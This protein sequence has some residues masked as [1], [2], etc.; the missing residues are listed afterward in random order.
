MKKHLFLKSLLIAIGLLVTSLTTQV[1]AGD[2][3]IDGFGLQFYED[4]SNPYYK[5]NGDIDDNTKMSFGNKTC[6]WTIAHVYANIKKNGENVCGDAWFGWQINGPTSTSWASPAKTSDSWGGDYHYT[7]WG[8]ENSSASRYIELVKNRKPG[9]Y[10]L[11]FIFSWKCD[12]SC[13]TTRYCKYSDHNWK[14]SW[15]IPEPTITITG[16]SSL[17]AGTSTNISASISNYPVG[18]TLTRVDVTGNLASPKYS[19]GTETS[20][21]V[22]SVTPN[23]SGANGIKVTVTVTYGTAGSKTYDYYYNVTPPATSD[24]TITPGGTGYLSSGSGTSGSPYLVT[25]NGT[26]TLGL[27]GATKAYDDGNSAAEYS[28][29]EGSSYGTTSSYTSKTISTITATSNADWTFKA[30]L[31][32]T[33]TSSLVGSVKEKTVYWKVPTYSVT[34][35][36]NG[37]STDGSATATHGKNTLSIGT[38]PTKTGYDVSGY[39][40]SDATPVLIATANGTLQTSTA[41]TDGSNKWNVLSGATL[42]AHWTAHTYTVTL[43]PGTGGSG[44][45]T[46]T[47]D[48]DA[49]AKKTWSHNITQTGYHITGWYNQTAAAGSVKV[50]N[51]DGSFAGSNV[52]GYITS[53]K[54][55]KASNCTLYAWWGGNTFTVSYD[56]NG[57]T[58][59]MSD[60]DFTYGTAQNLRT[61]TFYKDGYQFDGWATS[62]S[63]AKVYNDGVDGCRVST[64]ANITLYAHWTKVT[65]TDLTFTPATSAG[66]TSVTVTPVLSGTPTGTTSVCWGLYYDSECTRAVP[67]VTFGTNP[68]S[69][70]SSTTFTTPAASGS[71]Y[72]QATYRVGSNCSGTVLNTFVKQYVVA[73]EH[74]VIIKYKQGSTEIASRGNVVVPAAS[75]AGVKAPEIFGYTFSSWS[76]SE[77]LSNTCA[78]GASC[79]VAKDSIN[80]SATIDATLT[81]NYTRDNIIYLKNT[82]NWDTAYVNL[83]PNAWWGSDANGSGAGN[84]DLDAA[85]RNKGMKRVPGH[86]DIW[87]YNYGNTAT[88]AYV[89]FTNDSQ[90]NYYHF[91]G[92]DKNHRVSAIYPTRPNAASSENT[93]YGFNSG[94][95]M[96]VPISQTGQKWNG[97]TGNELAEYFNK[98]YWR[99]FEPATGE[100][101]YTLKIYNHKNNDGSRSLLYSV[102][103][104]DATSGSD[105]F[106][107]TIDLEAGQTYG[108]KIERDN[109]IVYTNTSSDISKN[110]NTYITLTKEANTNYAATGLATTVAGE[111]TIKLTCQNTGSLAIAAKYPAASNDYRLVYTDLVHTKKHPSDIVRRVNNGTDIVSFFVRNAKTPTVQIQSCTVNAGTG[112]VSW[113]NYG[114][115]I[116]LKTTFA[117][118]V[119]KDGVYNLYLSMNGSG[120][121]TI[122]SVKP[123][124]GDF[125]IRTDAVGGTKW[126]DYRN[127]AHKMTYS[128]YSAAN[129]GFTHYFVNWVA[130]NSNVKFTVANDYSPCISDTL[131]EDVGTVVATIIAE[132]N[133][134]AG[135][136]TSANANIRFMYNANDNSIKRAYLA[137]GQDW[138]SHFLVLQGEASKLLAPNGNALVSGNN[139]GVENNAIQLTDKQE[140]LYKTSV[141]AVPGGKVKLYARYNSVDQYFIG[142]SPIGDWTTAKAYEVLLSGDGG[143]QNISV[144][145]NFKTDRMIA[146]WEPANEINTELTLNADVMIVR[147]HQESAANITFSASD[148][149]L[150]TDKTIYGVMR[151]N[152]YV[153]NNRSTT[154]PHSVLPAGDQ[155]PLRERN[156]YYISFPFDVNVSD[157]FGFGT[158]GV[159]WVLQYY[160]GKDRAKNGLWSDPG[161]TYWKYV[162]PTGKLNKN[163]GYL[164]ALS[165][166]Q[167]AYDKTGTD[168]VW[169]HNREEVELYFPDATKG[170]TIG[171]TSVTIDAPGSD[172]QCNIWRGRETGEH[173]GD[174]NYDRRIADSY[175]RCIGVPSFKDFSTAL[176]DGT[177]AFAWSDPAAYETGDI[178]FLYEVQWADYSL[179]AVSGSTYNFQTMHAYITQNDKAIVW[180]PV[181]SIKSSI[182][183]RQRYAEDLKDVEFRLT[184]NRNDEVADQTFV[185]LTDDENVTTGFEFGHD[186]TK[187]LYSTKAN[188]FTYIG[189]EKVAANSLPIS[190]QTTIVPVGITLAETGEYT[191][192]VPDGTKGIGVTLVDNETGIRSNLAL[193]D[194][195][196]N[197]EAGSYDDRFILE[198]SPIKNTPTDIDLLNGENGADDIRKVMVDGMLYIVKDGKVFDAQGKRV[199]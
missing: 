113:T 54:W 182:V 135:K 140:W 13:N 63:G 81:A 189:Q 3:Y 116:N 17:V 14:I 27:S 164:L 191:F 94:T 4:G 73:S 59:S 83:Y 120:A 93:S 117:S 67:G 103:M 199:K 166:S 37:G 69:G 161:M 132:G 34:L 130:Q 2:S 194:Y 106:V 123:Y 126:A 124:T 172:Y 40:T 118:D 97:S 179:R 197:L 181:N 102:P 77:G 9:N 119:T 133:A 71:Y 152:K 177:S 66:N 156:H 86:R 147:N 90:N 62:P 158:Y 198:I 183:A 38:A 114:A 167:M 175:W 24:F 142:K 153:L 173:E 171:E 196:V 6:D 192:A 127:D 5:T 92:A 108:V 22:S 137:G 131:T 180:Y 82:L 165:P 160:D 155:L 112:A 46:M 28:I 70:A 41:Y 1:W 154:E 18:A 45:G 20:V 136:M 149:S 144:V 159:H 115:A 65:V 19:T 99:E 33:T 122:D 52:S 35:N 88:T 7:H 91:A 134:D 145:Y 12:G 195:I 74:T 30:R 29:N 95:P 48:Y 187:E 8:T 162:P 23:A 168:E 138:G 56:N 57:G 44:S 25:H 101:G 53:Y 64:G 84:H 128:E 89:S 31:K 39:Y 184:L 78:D 107:A 129:K 151:F 21:T 26:L 141:K 146:A 190:E 49:T 15:T 157:I 36:R 186:L 105:I 11:Q 32:N 76:L 143:A 75:S 121:L 96:F 188:I 163:E 148:K 61:N 139:N 170:A 80:I 58:G 42:Y 150:T 125:Y 104:T 47:V 85:K 87:Y 109:S 60:Q 111:Y 16:A 43:A 110:E 72:V 50:L 178:H 193:E 169:A 100:T 55:S 79:G 68:S 98:G 174:P 10:N 185:R 176:S 51:T